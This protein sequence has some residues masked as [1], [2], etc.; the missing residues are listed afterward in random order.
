[1]M[2]SSSGKANTLIASRRPLG[3]GLWMSIDGVEGAGKTAVMGALRARV[4]HAIVAPKFSTTPVGRFLAKA[5]RTAPYVFDESIIAQSLLFPAEFWETYDTVIR[6]ARQDGIPVISDRGYLSKFVVQRVVMATALGRERA[7]AILRPIFAA[8]C[9]P[10]VTVILSAPTAVIRERLINRDGSC[11]QERTRFLR[12]VVALFEDAP[13]NAGT[14]LRFDTST[15]HA[16]EIAERVIESLAEEKRR[17]DG[18]Q[19]N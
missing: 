17:G 1:M 3:P 11:D 12:A 7:D 13:S 5:V 15:A 9:A 14:L 2:V 4:E 10:D 16:D 6:K 8:M 19:L 18:D